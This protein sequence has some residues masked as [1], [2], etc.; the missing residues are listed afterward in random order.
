MSTPNMFLSR[1]KKIIN[2]FGLKK[3][4]CLIWSYGIA[5]FHVLLHVCKHG[6]DQS[7]C[8]QAK[9]ITDHNPAH[10]DFF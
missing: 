6:H 8:M 10:N 7:F 2:T 3:K 9:S 5:V 4:K 1:N